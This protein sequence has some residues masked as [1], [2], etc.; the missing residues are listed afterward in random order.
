[1]AVEGGDEVDEELP[2]HR[3]GGAL[4]EDTVLESLSNAA[5]LRAFRE[6]PA[7]MREVTWHWATGIPVADTACGM[8]IAPATVRVH[9]H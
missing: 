4:P 3:R 2:R 9:L 1:M 8:G 6:L 5:L 7:R